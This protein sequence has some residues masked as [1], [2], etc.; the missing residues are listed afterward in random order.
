MNSTELHP[1]TIALGKVRW[2]SFDL[3]LS[4]VN[5]RGTWTR[6][7]VRIEWALWNVLWN[8]ARKAWLIEEAKRTAEMN[9]IA[10]TL[11]ALDGQ[12]TGAERKAA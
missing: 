6:C 1:T 10:V 5:T 11:L 4:G 3:V 12:P 7:T 2:G 9:G 8:C